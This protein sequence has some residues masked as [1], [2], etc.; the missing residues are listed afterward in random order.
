MRQLR[1]LEEA[2]QERLAHLDQEVTAS[3]IRP[4]FAK[5]AA[6]Y[7]DW[8][9]VLAYL[10]GVQAHIVEHADDFKVKP[11]TTGED[12]AEEE[13]ANDGATPWL[14]PRAPRRSTNTA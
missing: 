14:Q 3:T 2:A 13:G 9:D 12:Q 7:G 11:D 5:L 8:P 10:E 1:E 6:E 4:V